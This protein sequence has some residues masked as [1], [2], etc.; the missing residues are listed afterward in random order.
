MTDYRP[1]IVEA[2]RWAVANKS[3]FDYYESRPFTLYKPNATE[4]ITDDCS[5]T[6][7]LMCW[8]SGA[9]EPFPGAYNYDGQHPD[10]GDG[11]TE[12]FLS[13]EHVTNPVG[14]DFVVYGEGLPLV[15]QHMAVVLE[16]GPDPLTMSHGMPSEPAFVK[17]IEGCPPQAQG[18][19]TYVRYLPLSPPPEDTVGRRL[20]QDPVNHGWWLVDEDRKCGIPTP[21]DLAT[22]QAEGIPTAVLSSAEL[23][24]LTTV[25][26]GSL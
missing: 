12:S 25:P 7:V 3:F 23:A 4:H 9:P 17:A 2:S 5:A 13:L 20:V 10:Q 15:D 14:G 24:G 19:I 8:L 11:N 18:I 1:L 6:S 26:W 16:S 22:L 21:T